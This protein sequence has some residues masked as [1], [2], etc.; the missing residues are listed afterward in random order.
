MS[1]HEM[2]CVPLFTFLEYFP[3]ESVLLYSVNACS[4]KNISECLVQL[5][6]SLKMHKVAL[7]RLEMTYALR[8]FSE[9]YL[10]MF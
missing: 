5:W 1:T 9:I 7:I 3:N 2:I 6:K 4:S 10:F 8:S